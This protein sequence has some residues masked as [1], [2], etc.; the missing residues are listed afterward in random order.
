MIPVRPNISTR[1][2][3]LAVMAVATAVI[4]PMLFL[5]NASG[6]DFQ[7]HVASWVDVARQW[8]SGVL[9]PRW[10]ARANFGFGEPRFI[11]YPP[12]SWLLGAALGTALPWKVVPGAFVW[13]AVVLAG[14][15]M[16]WLAREWLSSGAAVVA[17]AFYA[18]NPYHLVLIYYRSDF[19]ELLASAALPLAALLA[20]RVG[21]GGS[22]NIVTLALVFA[23]IW[24]SN[25]PAAVVI[26]Y[27]LA[28]VLLVE[29]LVQKS[30][31]ALLRG[32]V[33]LA[34]GLGL[35]A[36][37][38]VPAAWEQKWV[39]IAQVMSENLHP[40]QNFLFTRAN[41]PEFVLFNWKVSAVA[42]GVI[43][44]SA[45]AAVFSS[46]GRRAGRPRLDEAWWPLAALGAVSV[47]LMFAPAQI[48]WRLLPK[49]RFVQFP[50]RWLVPL[51]LVCWFFFVHATAR[52]R[53]AWMWW[54]AMA[55]AIAILAGVIVQ[56]AW[57]DSEDVPVISSAVSSG[58]GYEGTDE[59]A[60]LGC[61]RYDLPAEAPRI[62]VIGG[63]PALGG[64]PMN[65]RI[66]IERWTPELKTFSVDSHR[67]TT[68]ALKLL[69]YPAWQAEVN[70]KE[71]AT[72]SKP[73]T[74][75]MLLPLPAGSSHVEVRFSRTPDRTL[76]DA[77]S[78]L[79]A[80]ALA[81]LAFF[82]RRAK[83]LPPRQ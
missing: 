5:G 59:Y 75:Q 70:G 30:P 77:L 62:A 81:A 21:R 39:E 52:A 38:I 22:R 9:Y 47:G 41:D 13:L 50:W 10:A 15:S 78:L 72:M 12:A 3:L 58:G 74:E 76:G 65:V 66:H 23:F 16:F 24:L 64:Q 57:W 36:F 20:I 67:G 26:S 82:E 8:R 80:A 43:T 45:I 25:A 37:Y 71:I 35:A 11:F 53:K 34:C 44:I 48:V 55:V 4:T 73:G 14:L 60:P 49:L 40:D 61:D 6:H 46:R 7:F 27:S 18:A 83:T 79:T 54:V 19:A 2:A 32:A 56:D 69:N 51:N 42:L 31:R 29:S 28:L 63:V 17:A 68:L 1:H 33:A